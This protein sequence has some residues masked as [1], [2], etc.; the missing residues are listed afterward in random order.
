MFFAVT[1]W[2]AGRYL[3]ALLRISDAHKLC[4]AWDVRM[5]NSCKRNGACRSH[6]TA[7][8][9]G[10]HNEGGRMGV[11]LSAL[12]ACR[13]GH[14]AFPLPLTDDFFQWSGAR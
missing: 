1:R 10:L 12:P 5:R 2:S 14:E 3:G 6:L 4:K 7:G 11:F 13:K 9:V 8:S